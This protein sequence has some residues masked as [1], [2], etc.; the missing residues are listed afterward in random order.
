MIG[1]RTI[2]L[3]V[4][5]AST[6]AA[7]PAAQAKETRAYL[8]VIGN[9]EPPA[10]PDG[11]SLRRLQY[12]DDDAIGYY[13]LLGQFAR[14]ATLLATL[15]DAT[16]RRYPGL[17]D[18]AG[19][20]TLAE[21]LA[22]VARYRKAMKADIARGDRPVLYLTF[23]GHGAVGDDGTAYLALDDSPLTQKVLYE[24]ILDVLPTTYTHIIVD[25]CHAGGVVGVRGP[26]PFARETS[27]RTAELEARD[28][29]PLLQKSALAQRSAVGAIVATTLGQEA[30]EWSEIEGGV[31]SHEV[32]SALAGAADVNGDRKIEYSEVQAFIAAA[33]RE[34]KD[35]RAAPRVVAVAPRRNRNVPLV[36]LDSLASATL[37]KGKAGK[38]G[39]F[40]IELEGGERYL[41]AHLSPE[42]SAVLAIP[43]G[44]VAYLR[45]DNHEAEIPAGTRGPIDL[46]D[47]RL[48]RRA[49]ASRGSLDDDYR[50]GLFAAPYGPTYYRGFV[51]SVGATGV[52]WLKPQIKTVVIEREARGRRWPAVSVGIAAGIAGAVSLGFAARAY[53]DY[54]SLGRQ[55]YQE[56]A[57]YIAEDYRENMTWAVATGLIAATG[58]A[59]AWRLWPDGPTVHAAPEQ[60][61]QGGAVQIQGR[62]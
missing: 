53:N 45:T 25:A 32:Q 59:V 21:I 15:D 7:Q 33:N 23:S 60:T 14:E 42:A 1:R 8:L 11:Q 22:T 43:G 35:P 44:Q 55:M 58:A 34:I 18:I 37:L 52:V 5:A 46:D 9:N 6:M 16:Q 2:A 28:L 38:L 62:F 49:V 30:H 56:R 17:A 50:R 29:L 47:L 41:D 51:D 57:Q 12:A 20:P 3:L 13:R 19:K 54:S 24:Q 61:G 48:V 31:F 36:D 26:D 4:L 27:A 10:G 39:H 40:Y